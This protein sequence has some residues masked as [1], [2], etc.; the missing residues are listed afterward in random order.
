VDLDSF[1]SIIDSVQSL[2]PPWCGVQIYV[3][4][5]NKSLGGYATEEEAA[6][7]YDQAVLHHKL[8]RALLNFP[9]F[10]EVREVLV[11]ESYVS[12]RGDTI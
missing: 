4:G 1:H 2:S 11:D 12:N 3:G 7:A 5:T 10:A 6:F 8:N 9:S